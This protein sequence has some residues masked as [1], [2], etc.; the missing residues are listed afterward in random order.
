M[1]LELWR[2]RY[3]RKHGW[4]EYLL[5]AAAVFRLVIMLLPVNE[6]NRVVPLQPWSTIR[7]MPLTLVGL[8]VAYLIMRDARKTGD[9]TFIWIGT[10]ILVSYACYIP[11]ILFVQ[12]IP[13]IGMLM[14]PK[15]MAYVAIGF[16]AY[17]ELYRQPSRIASMMLEKPAA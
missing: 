7:N 11:V 16:L 10:M 3:D 13:M 17:N 14:I 4:F 12:Q 6:W 2:V 1:M 5:L 8:G 15:T 9:S